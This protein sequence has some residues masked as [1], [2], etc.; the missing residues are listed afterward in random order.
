MK[1]K[2]VYFIEISSVDDPSQIFYFNGEML[3][4]DG[5]TSVLASIFRENAT[6]FDDTRAAQSIASA[7]RSDTNSI[8]RNAWIVRSDRGEEYDYNCNR[9]WTEDV[10]IK[11]LDEYISEVMD[12]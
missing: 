8:F 12:I 3:N 2:N 7:I 10:S 6:L 1:P 9:Y 5:T 4:P 11:N